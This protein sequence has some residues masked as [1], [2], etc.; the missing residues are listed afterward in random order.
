M[1]AIQLKPVTKTKK[2]FSRKRLRSKELIPPSSWGLNEYQNKQTP[3]TDESIHSQPLPKRY[4]LNT[5]PASFNVAGTKVSITHLQQPTGEVHVLS[6]I[7]P[8]YSF[9]QLVSKIQQSLTLKQNFLQKSKAA[10]QADL[11]LLNYMDALR[12]STVGLKESMVVAS[13]IEAKIKIHFNSV[14]RLLDQILAAS[15]QRLIEVVETSVAASIL[16]ANSI[17]AIALQSDDAK[18][19]SA[20]L[21]DLKGGVERPTSQ[22]INA[23]LEIQC[24]PIPEVLKNDTLLNLLDFIKKHRATN[25]QQILV[26]VGAALRKVLLNLPASDIGLAAELMKSEG[27]LAVPVGVEL[28]IAKMVVQRVIEDPSINAS[29]FPELADAL[30]SNAK[31]YSTPKM[32]N[33]EFYNATALNSVLGCILL[34]S[35]ESHSLAN[36]VISDSPSWFSRLCSNRFTRIRNELLAKKDSMSLDLVNHL[37]SLPF[38]ADGNQKHQVGSGS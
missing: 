28:E 38:L 34:R 4:F 22:A 37:N 32:V 23:V 29:L 25:S 14:T 33:R 24:L 19:F 13:E 10:T 6:E 15:N 17:Q 8:K 30:L 18:Q 3:T 1:N 27:C 20:I 2:K 26:A 7:V 36:Q 5:E 35:T 21:D 9:E 31:L 16:K 12:A 11:I